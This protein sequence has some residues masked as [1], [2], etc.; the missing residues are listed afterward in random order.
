M[1]FHYQPK[2]NILSLSEIFNLSPVPVSTGLM[3][4]EGEK[5]YPIYYEF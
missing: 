3:S 5:S 1:N 2:L 4:Y